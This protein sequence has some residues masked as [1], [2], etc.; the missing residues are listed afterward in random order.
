L[1]P[2]VGFDNVFPCWICNC[3]SLITSRFETVLSFV[4]DINVQNT[5]TFD[6]ICKRVLPV[7][8]LVAGFTLSTSALASSETEVDLEL[9]DPVI[10]KKGSITASVR[11]VNNG[12]KDVSVNVP[13]QLEQGLSLSVDGSA[14]DTSVGS[15]NNTAKRTI[16]P[17][18]FLGKTVK[19]TP[20]KTW[21]R[22]VKLQVQWSH[23]DLSSDTKTGYYFPGRVAKIDVE[24]YAPLR[25]EFYHNDAPANVFH[26]QQLIRNEAYDGTEFHRLI[27][28]YLLQGGSGASSG[29]QES[30]EPEFS[31]RKHQLG[32]VSMAH[33]RET[34][35]SGTEFFITLGRQPMLDGHYTV[36]GRVKQASRSVLQQ[37]QE[38]VKTDHEEVGGICGVDHTDQ[39]KSPLVM[40][41]VR[42]TSPDTGSDQS[43]K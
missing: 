40:K 32:T 10:V 43:D 29:D 39:P 15:S 18:E 28:G 35:T 14:V 24:G 9:T 42:L 31:D 5:R 2:E 13:A 41:T 23:K 7:L 22:P 3:F 20:K 21:D 16:A 6:R 19:V 30:V 8:L 17:G 36:I 1:I 26:V 25:V 37:I 34:R 4:M 12:E 38:Q 11:I 27:D 33:G